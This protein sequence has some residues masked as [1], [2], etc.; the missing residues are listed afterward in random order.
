MKKQWTALACVL[1]MS[2]YIAPAIAD[3][4]TEAYK[5]GLEALSDGYGH[6]LVSYCVGNAYDPSA[7]QM[8]A[9]ADAER[10]F[11][12]GTIAQ[13]GQCPFEFGIWIATGSRADGFKEGAQLIN[14]LSE[15]TS[16]ME[17]GRDVFL[18]DENGNKLPAAVT[19][20]CLTKYQ[21]PTET[22]STFPAG[23]T[24]LAVIDD[25]DGYTNMRSQ[26]SAKSQIVARVTRDEQFF[27]YKQ[28]DNWWQVRTSDG[29]VGYIHISRIRL[30]N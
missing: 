9:Y 8:K 12:A 1:A 27:T 2:L 13:A 25:P 28:D 24:H 5:C 6:G 17:S 29:K 14:T 15:A 3:E 16:V 21:T 18:Y 7:L 22:H 11:K 30:L 10:D 20:L 4:Y 23:F 26:K 19:D